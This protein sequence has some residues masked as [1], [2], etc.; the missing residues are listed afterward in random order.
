MGMQLIFI[1]LFIPQGDKKYVYAGEGGFLQSWQNIDI[2][3][4][5][6]IMG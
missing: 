3:A 6:F 4:V 5:E 1:F 2:I